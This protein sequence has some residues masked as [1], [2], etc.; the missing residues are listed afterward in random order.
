MR[1]GVRKWSR[2]ADRA[3]L[4]LPAKQQTHAKRGPQELGW[5]YRNLRLIALPF[6]PEKNP[7]RMKDTREVALDASS[8]RAKHRATKTARRSRRKE[9]AAATATF[10]GAAFPMKQ[11][12]AKKKQTKKVKAA[13]AKAK[14][15]RRAAASGAAGDD[16]AMGDAVARADEDVKIVEAEADAKPAGRAA[17]ALK[18][19]ARRALKLKIDNLKGARSKIAKRDIGNKSTRKALS[20]NIKKLLT[21]GKASAN[22]ARELLA[23]AADV[24]ED[25][26]D[27]EEDVEMAA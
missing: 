12:A 3:R 21:V 2:P 20:S 4:S 9:N 19:Q 18:V 7:P 16:V 17:H 8:R 10:R 22:D 24:P 5:I 13:K 1:V 14:A 27:W 23:A 6:F 15:A 11:R 26:D 25:D